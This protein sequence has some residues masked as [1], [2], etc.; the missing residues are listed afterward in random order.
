MAL[1]VKIIWGQR[2]GW[3]RPDA[4]IFL[5]PRLQYHN[6]Q[7]IRRYS[8]DAKRRLVVVSAS[9]KKHVPV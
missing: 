4:S 9:R 7:V 5:F 1:Q 6:W 8:H 3:T 2:I